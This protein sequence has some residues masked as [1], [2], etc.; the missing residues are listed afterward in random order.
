M[1]LNFTP[2]P[3]VVVTPEGVEIKR[4]ESSGL[5]RLKAETIDTGIEIDGVK[6]TKT[7]FGEP[8]GLPDFEDGVFIIVS[9][10]VKSALPHR[11]DLLVPAEVV[12]D[13]QGNILGCQSLGA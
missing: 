6:I 13:S 12:R 2:H 8:V 4:I 7:Q 5:I 3:I 10:L 9:Q 11:T 1:I